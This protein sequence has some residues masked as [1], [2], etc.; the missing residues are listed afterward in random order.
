MTS[1][2]A[3]VIDLTKTTVV[4]EKHKASSAEN[5]TTTSH[6][7]LRIQPYLSKLDIPGAIT[8]SSHL[9]FVLH[10]VDPGHQLTHTTVTQCIP[11]KWLDVWDQHD[12]VEDLVAEVLRLGVEAAGQEYVVSRM[13]W[14]K[15]EMAEV[16]SGS[17][18]VEVS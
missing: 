10:L 6:V 2:Q 9:Q 8:T 11:S 3:N 16:S 5:P 14:V 15:D 17:V 1:I 13:G 12:W 18:H 4:P 7:Y